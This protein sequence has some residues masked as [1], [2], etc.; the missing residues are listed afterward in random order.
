[1]MNRTSFYAE[2]LTDITTRS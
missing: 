1:M 2:I